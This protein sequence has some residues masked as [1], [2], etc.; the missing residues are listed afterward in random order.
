MSAARGSGEGD[1]E[2]AG[3]TGSLSIVDGVGVGEGEETGWD[4]ETLAAFPWMAAIKASRGSF[5]GAEGAV[6]E[7][8]VV[9]DELSAEFRDWIAENI[10]ARALRREESSGEVGGVGFDVSAAGVDG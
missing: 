9:S 10:A 3:R 2:D 7:V 5:A 1:G 8:E 4:D 6:E